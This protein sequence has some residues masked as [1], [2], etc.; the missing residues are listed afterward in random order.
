MFPTPGLPSSP[1][2]T[3]AVLQLYSSIGCLM[4]PRAAFRQATAVPSG[5]AGRWARNRECRSY[6]HMGHL[7]AGQNV[8]GERLDPDGW[9][10]RIRR[11]TQTNKNENRVASFG[12]WSM[13]ADRHELT[14][15][16]AFSIKKRP[17]YCSLLTGAFLWVAPSGCSTVWFS[18]WGLSICRFSQFESLPPTRRR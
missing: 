15:Q 11:D 18:V 9:L 2:L 17:L 1:L 12:G 10:S 8:V 7:A 5:E 16:S 3:L 6:L 13:R 14:R 4:V